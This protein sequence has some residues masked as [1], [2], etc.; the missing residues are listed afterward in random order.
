MSKFRTNILLVV[1]ASNYFWSSVVVVVKVD[2]F[3]V[4][5]FFSFFFFAQT[6]TNSRKNTG[7]FPTHHVSL[8]SILA[9]KV[10]EE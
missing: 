4:S 2:Y 6:C 9:P 8:I 1:I 3:D 10:M 5:H 7:V